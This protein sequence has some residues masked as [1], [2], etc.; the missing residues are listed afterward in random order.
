M[1]RSS[2]SSCPFVHAYRGVSFA[3]PVYW[4]TSFRPQRRQR[5][6]PDNSAAPRFG[7]PCEPARRLFLLTICRSASARSQS[8]Y[9]LW[10]EVTNWPSDTHKRTDEERVRL[11][12]LQD[13]A[14]ARL[15]RQVGRQRR[16]RCSVRCRAVRD[17][18]G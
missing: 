8:I 17:D 11:A 13:Q 3:V 18:V 16:G 9:P 5:S 7:G 14:I 12:A 10:P 4:T 1:Q 15:I 6:S 2:P